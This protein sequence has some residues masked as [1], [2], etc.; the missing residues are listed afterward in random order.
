MN[1]FCIPKYPL[2]NFKTL[3]LLCLTL[4]IS[5]ST[6]S[7][8]FKEIVV[9][10]LN[11]SLESLTGN[12]KFNSSGFIDKIVTK[13]ENRIN[14]KNLSRV[15]K[16]ETSRKTYIVKKYNNNL[17]AFEI[18]KKGD[19]SL[20]K[21]LTKYFLENKDNGFRELKFNQHNGEDLKTF[22]HGDISPYAN[23][24]KSS[25][26]LIFKNSTAI[27]LYKLKKII[28]SYNNCNLNSDI[29]ISDGA[30]KIAN[31]SKEKIKLGLSLGYQLID[32]KYDSFGSDLA[33]DFGF[34]TVGISAF[35]HPFNL[36]TD[37]IR[38]GFSLDFPV[39][40]VNHKEV[41]NDGIIFLQNKTVYTSTLFQIDYIIDVSQSF[42]AY[43]GGKYGIYFNSGSSIN[44][45]LP[46]DLTQDDL[47]KFE[48]ENAVGYEIHLGAQFN[49]IN[50]DFDF[51]LGYKPKVNF[52]LQANSNIPNVYDVNEPYYTI[53]SF[54]FKLTYLF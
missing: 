37:N 19:I 33:L 45:Y 34:Q 51:S 5:L 11:N 4:S 21:S 26:N 7:Q 27:N 24:C 49:F 31:K 32:A 20:Y 41:T 12:L 29:Q 8:N 28:D 36:K 35:F 25:Q 3:L 16:I 22:N 6:F 42:K 52:S 44:I 1:Y 53:N 14:Y 50:Q 30:I 38:L 46:N 2:M 23:K 13:N 43:F 48:T 54:N 40:N 9:Y 17:Y 39:S 10:D 15:S 47:L 18:I